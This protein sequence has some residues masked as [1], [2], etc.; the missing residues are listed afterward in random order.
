MTARQFSLRFV[1]VIALFAALNAAVWS[2]ATR[3]ILTRTGETITG[4]LARIG[5][6][7]DLVHARVNHTDLA[8]RHLES[9][10][11]RGQAIDLLSIGDSFSQGAGGGPNRYYQDHIAAT[12]DW[13]VLNLQDPPASRSSLETAAALA[14]SGFLRRAGVRYLLIEVTQRRAVERLSDPAHLKTALD[15]RDLDAYYRFGDGAEASFDFALPETRFINDGNLKYLAY[16]ALYPFHDCALV[17]DTCRVR[18]DRRLFSIGDGDEMLFYRKD[19]DAI[20][21]SSAANIQRM[22]AALNALAARLKKE[23]VTL[24]FMPVVGKYSLYRDHFTDASYPRDAFFDLLR[25]QPHDYLLIDTKAI[26]DQGIQ[27][28]EQD[29]FYVDDTHWSERASRR[30]ARAFAAMIAPN[31]APQRP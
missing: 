7:S 12:L 16:R 13:T 3:A 26:L 10:D 14:D 22:N 5:Y 21:H 24:V 6:V 4:D 18:L 15:R 11:Y 25:Q 19:R 31:G 28:G 20:R 27:A 23:G 8:R 30:I 17:S 29:I 2:L 1:V 9:G